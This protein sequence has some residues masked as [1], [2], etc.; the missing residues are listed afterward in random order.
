MSR[1]IAF[2]IATIG[3]IGLPA[4][5]QDAYPPVAYPPPVAQPPPDAYPPPVAQPPQPPPSAVP[6][7]PPVYA[8]EAALPAPRYAAPPMIVPV[9]PLRPARPPGPN[10]FDR[11]HRVGGQLGGTGIFQIVYRYRAAGPVHLEIGAAG[12]HGANL[13]AG[14]VVGGPFANRWFP[15]FGFGGGFMIGGGPSNEGCDPGATTCPRRSDSFPFLHARV[16]I[17]VGFGA[18]R[19]NLLSLDVGGWYGRHDKS[20]TDAAGHTTESS[21]MIALPMAGLSY[22][23]AV[24]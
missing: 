2:V 6:S 9:Q 5:A 14:A 16:G 1:S 20:E 10:G 23:F 24:H 7:P 4:R 18:T 13:S 3:T 11:R 12:I 15:Y 21:K 8:S 19:R 17:G 22:F